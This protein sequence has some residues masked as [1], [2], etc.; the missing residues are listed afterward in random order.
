MIW[1]FKKT[2]QLYF[3]DIVFGI[4][5]PARVVQATKASVIPDH[6]MDQLGKEE[7]PYVTL[8]CD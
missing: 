6:R 5:L 1:Q 8:D 4:V 7:N 3:N 2:G